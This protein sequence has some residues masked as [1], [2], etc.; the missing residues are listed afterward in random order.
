MN[1]VAPGL[2]EGDLR[3]I[4]EGFGLGP[5]RRVEFLPGG[6]MNRNWRIE[7]AAG[8]FA[9][10]LL[11]D[12]SAEVACRN[13][14]VLVD[15][16]AAGLPV[17]APVLTPA[18]EVLFQAGSGDY[19][20]SSWAE[21]AHREGT[22]LSSGETESFGSLVAD[23]HNALHAQIGASLPEAGEAPRAKITAAERALEK[24]D[25]LLTR[26]AVIPEPTSFDMAARDLLAERKVLIEKH[27]SCIPSGGTGGWLFGWTHGDLQYRNVLHHEGTVSAVLD[28]DRIAVRRLGE[29][30]AR[31]AQV[32]FGGEHGYLDLERV[33]A[34]VTGYRAVKPLPRDDLVEAVD[35]LWWKRMSDFWM[36]EFHYDRGDHGPD[37]LMEPS[38]RLLAWWTD[39]RDEVQAAFAA[40]A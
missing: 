23:I 37:A 26:I 1:A 16:R 2:E 34:F 27:R 38:E 32:Q 24:A 21:G 18:G 15:L 17:C 33:A 12:V 28:W 6:I 4:A 30:V 35:R 40:G 10:K 20:V 13:A 36:F 29:E 11:L 31:T 25:R 22:D 39:Q 8:S 5:V 14:R 3:I 19:L 9:L 7:T